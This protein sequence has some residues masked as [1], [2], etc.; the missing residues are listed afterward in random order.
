MCGAL[1]N[2][3]VR[4]TDMNAKV[5]SNCRISGNYLHHLLPYLL[6]ELS[7]WSTY[8]SDG[9]ILL[10]QLRLIDGVDQKRPEESC[11]LSRPSLGNSNDVTPTQCYGDGLRLDGCRLRELRLSDQSHE[12]VVET[13]VSK[14]HTR[15]GRGIPRYLEEER[16]GERHIISK[17]TCT[18][19]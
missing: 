10:L 17:I 15:F 4:L 11:S 14:G 1:E 8:Q 3:S 2:N 16:E 18:N 12:L 13:K 19:E 5:P 7:C 9:P 6:A